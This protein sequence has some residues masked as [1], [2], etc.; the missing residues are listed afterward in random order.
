MGN[1]DFD[2]LE[3]DDAALYDFGL[4]LDEL[5]CSKMTSL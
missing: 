5:F 4:A 3:G 1:G 2:H